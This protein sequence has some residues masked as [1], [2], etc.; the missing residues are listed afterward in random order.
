M[1][2]CVDGWVIYLSGEQLSINAH[3]KKILL[4]ISSQQIQPTSCHSVSLSLSV[5]PSA[6]PTRPRLGLHPI[7]VS[8]SFFCQYFSGGEQA[9]P[10][11]RW[12]GRK[13]AWQSQ[14]QIFLPRFWQGL[15]LPRSLGS[16]LVIGNSSIVLEKI[17]SVTWASWPLSLFEARHWRSPRDP[18]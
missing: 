9:R 17:S 5:S 18:W 14:C 13:P 1:G 2:K 16:L 7:I 3:Q 12:W 10:R 11:R 6:G 15:Y 8:G 4:A